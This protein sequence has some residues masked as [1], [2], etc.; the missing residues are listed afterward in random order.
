MTEQNAETTEVEPTSGEQ[1]QPQEPKVF[2]A[3]Y[4]AGL[5][6][7][8]AKYRTEA[9]DAAAALEEQRQA[10]M[11]EAERAVAEAERRGRT[12]AASE[13]GQRLATSEIRALAAT[14]GADLT[15]VFDYLDLNRFVVDGEPNTEAISQFVAGL[16]RRGAQ[17]PNFD[18]GT[19][20]SVPA[21][22]FNQILRRAAGRA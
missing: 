6:K 14:E 13:Y 7:E 1:D 20:G 5:R 10:S 3:E 15:G 19:R 18:G 11:T 8:A 12:T 16:P 2:D 17:A 9:R 22:D 4:V 21:D